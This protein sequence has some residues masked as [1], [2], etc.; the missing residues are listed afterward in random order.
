MSCSV[1]AAVPDSVVGALGQLAVEDRQAGA[2]RLA[3]ALLF[4]RDDPDDEVAVL[5]QVG[6]R[7]AHDGDGGLDQRRHH[8]LLGA[9]QVGVADGAAQDPPQH[10]AAVLVGGEHPVV[11]E[12]RA[13]SGVLG[14]D[15][16]AKLSRS[17]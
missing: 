5:Q 17:S 13:G 9:E 7:V 2:Q 10:V 1:N 3:E 14:E 8:E 6:V 15:P 16:Q 11:H 12:H 4:P